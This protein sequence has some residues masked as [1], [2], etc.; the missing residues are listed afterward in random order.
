M[1]N[2]ASRKAII[3]TYL[4]DNVTVPEIAKR[5]KKS[6]QYVKEVLK[7]FY[8]SCIN[9]YR[10][11][12][13]KEKEGLIISRAGAAREMGLSRLDFERFYMQKYGLD[14]FDMEE[15]LNFLNEEKKRILNIQQT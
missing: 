1:T 14:L 6:P 4:E 13:E 10:F 7:S 5:V 2:C 9:A 11:L 3:D 15:G 8:E 12:K